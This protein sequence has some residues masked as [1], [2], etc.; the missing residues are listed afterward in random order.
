MTHRRVA[1]HAYSANSPRLPLR[2]APA[3]SPAKPAG[4]HLC[5]SAATVSS[6][7]CC[8]RFP[9]AEIIIIIPHR[10]RFPTVG[11]CGGEAWG[12][13]EACGRA[14]SGLRCGSGP[15]P[16]P[17]VPVKDQGASVLRVCRLDGPTGQTGRSFFRE[18][19][20]QAA[21]PAS[22]VL[23]R[24]SRDALNSRP[25]GHHKPRA[26]PPDQSLVQSVW[27]SRGQGTEPPGT[28]RA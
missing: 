27:W 17:R 22:R 15:C 26:L 11:A 8:S 28:P 14:C 19:W 24:G 12:R 5:L 18:V 13:P 7:A 16:V 1:P 9:T 2:T 4:M 25:P 21:R 23:R 3:G 6:P 20:M 10:G